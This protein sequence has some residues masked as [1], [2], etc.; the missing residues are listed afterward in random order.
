VGVLAVFL[1]AAPHV[2]LGLQTA[3]ASACGSIWRVAITPLDTL[4]TTLQVSGAGGYD[5]LLSRV[6][7]AGVGTLWNGALANASASFVGSFPWFFTFNLLDEHLPPFNVLL[8]AA[9]MGCV[10]TAVSDVV[11][12]SL[13]VVKVSASE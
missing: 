1:S 3:L 6:K 11:S 4:K 7:T 5:L 8:R 9:V 2:P 10:A 12:N 13:R